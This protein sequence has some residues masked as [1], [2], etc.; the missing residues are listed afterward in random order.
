MKKYRCCRFAYHL[1]SPIRYPPRLCPRN[2]FYRRRQIYFCPKRTDVL[3][4]PVSSGL[5]DIVE[6]DKPLLPAPTHKYNRFQNDFDVSLDNL[7]MDPTGP[8]PGAGITQNILSEED[9]ADAASRSR[10]NIANQFDIHD[11][12]VIRYGVASPSVFKKMVIPTAEADKD[13]IFEVALHEEFTGL[14]EKGMF[15][16]VCREPA[17]GHR[18]YTSRFV[19]EIKDY[20]TPRARDKSR[21]V[22]C[23]H[24]DRQHGLLT[25]APTVQR[26]SYRIVLSV[27]SQQPNRKVA[28]GD[29]TQ[30]FAQSRTPVARPIFA[31]APTFLGLGHDII[32]MLL[33]PLYGLSESGV[34]WLYR[35][36]GHHRSRLRIRHAAYGYCSLYSN[37]YFGDALPVRQPVNQAAPQTTVKFNSTSLHVPAEQGPR[38]IV[39][40][41]VDDTLLGDNDE[42]LALEEREVQIFDHKPRTVLS[43]HT[44]MRFNGMTIKEDDD[45]VIVI[46]MTEHANR[47]EPIPKD[48]KDPSLFVTERAKGA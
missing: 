37:G 38:G 10:L 30:A 8:I 4:P 6:L 17:D 28:S 45:R 22:L 29:I 35:Y 43:R 5:L 47:S 16:F 9:K 21:F 11:Y 7:I 46:E 41:H 13:P 24:G 3:T 19:D 33:Y 39:A 23:G 32:L 42:F 27:N 1:K 25:H 26:C 20:G 31:K 2:C 14:L 44:P 48:S 15:K 18:V 12:H 36:H 40:M 34:H